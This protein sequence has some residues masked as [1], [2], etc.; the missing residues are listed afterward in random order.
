M[1][2]IR[3]ADGKESATTAPT[4][5]MTLLSVHELRQVVGGEDANLPKGGWKPV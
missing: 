1:N 3:M 5:P 4:N 2:A